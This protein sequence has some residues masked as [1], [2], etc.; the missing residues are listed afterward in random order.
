LTYRQLD[1]QLGAFSGRLRT[2]VGLTGDE[3]AKV[4][5]LVAA[6]VRFLEPSERAAVFA[7]SPVP[8]HN[9][10]DE[11]TAFQ[12]F[13]DAASRTRGNGPLT[14]A[15]VIVQNYVCF[16]YLSEACFLALRKGSKAGSVTQ[17]CCKFLTDNPIRAF[18]NAI[19]HSNWSYAVDFGGLVFWARRGSAS[20][21]ALS[22]FEV[23]QG[24][25]GFWQALARAVAY[26]AYTSI[27]AAEQ[28]NRR[29][30]DGGTGKLG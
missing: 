20:N 15:Q 6:E 16:V 24:E 19:A 26:A 28:N 18:R 22:R 17:R 29:C 12:A 14:R 3:A 25:L 27:E 13:M 2:A 5:T 1:R 10:L 21:E 4:A 8:L 7:A 9:R 30:L 11:L 23:S